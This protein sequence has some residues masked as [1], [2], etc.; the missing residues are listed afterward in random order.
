MA[1]VVTTAAKQLDPYKFKPGESGNPNGRPK[2]SKHKLAESF[3]AD[4]LNEWEA[5]GATAIS[6]M[7]EKNPGDFVKMVASLLPKEM[8]LNV[9]SEIEMTDDELLERIRVLTSAI[10]PFLERAGEAGAGTEAQGSPAQPAQ[11]H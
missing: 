4:C 6:D 7:R 2:G 3:L 5:H 11:L 1:E 10:T 9:N 8:T